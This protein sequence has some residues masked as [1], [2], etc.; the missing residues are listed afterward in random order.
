MGLV[1]SLLFSE[2]VMNAVSLSLLYGY[3]W[4]R[5]EYQHYIMSEGKTGTLLRSCHRVR[6]QRPQ[7]RR[8]PIDR[9]QLDERS[10]VEFLASSR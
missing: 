7:A 4:V 1:V 8:D 5:L 6:F 3:C 10:N 9:A 2:V